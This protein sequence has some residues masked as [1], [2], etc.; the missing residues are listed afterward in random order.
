[1]E[2]L[3][4]RQVFSQQISIPSLVI[5]FAPDQDLELNGVLIPAASWRMERYRA[6]QKKVLNT[7]TGTGHY[8]S[9]TISEN[10]YPEW[11][12]DGYAQRGMLNVPIVFTLLKI[13]NRVIK[14]QGHDEI[15]ME[16][17]IHLLRE[18]LEKPVTKKVGPRFVELKT[19]YE[20]G[21]G[22]NELNT[23]F[24]VPGEL[25]R[26]SGLGINRFQKSFRE[27]HG[28][29]LQKMIQH[30]KMKRALE[31]ILLDGK[32][33]SHTSLELGYQHTANFITAFHKHFDITP[34]EAS[35]SCFS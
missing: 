26:S 33:I 12:I 15:W 22:L 29:S 10:H 32:S 31:S 8:F 21:E 16:A 25:V 23:N 3:R 20:M 34:M 19:I 5:D 11:G 1:M 27:C 28:L 17:Y 30:L 2:Q 35:R 4:K 6:P 7:G 24:P 13:I 14:P 9:I 18:Q